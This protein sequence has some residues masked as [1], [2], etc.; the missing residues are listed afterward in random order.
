MQKQWKFLLFILQLK[1][2]KNTDEMKNKANEQNAQLWNEPV[3][4][5]EDGDISTSGSETEEA[6]V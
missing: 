3:M 5:E 1:N 6:I 4:E 2:C